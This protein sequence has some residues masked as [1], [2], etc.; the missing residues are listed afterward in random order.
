MPLSRSR[1]DKMQ[2]SM[3]E[4]RSDGWCEAQVWGCQGRAT[5]C[6]HRIA[7]KA[8]GRPKGDDRRLSN[9]WHGCRACHQWA[10]LHPAAAY[11]MGLALREHQHD[12]EA[13]PIIRRGYSVLLFDD[14]TIAASPSNSSPVG[15]DGTV[16][17]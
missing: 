7:A 9:V 2:R 4:A 11:E 14:G 8:G 13:Q 5:D 3:L 1:A 10:T 16:G 6:C 12:T 15:A 17:T